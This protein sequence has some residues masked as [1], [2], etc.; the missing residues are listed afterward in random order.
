MPN[1]RIIPNV[2]PGILVNNKGIN[3]SRKNI[4]DVDR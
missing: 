3:I 4:F 1:G 2:N